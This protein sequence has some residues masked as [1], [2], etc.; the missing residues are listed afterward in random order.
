ML[1]HKREGGNNMFFWN[2]RKEANRKAKEEAEYHDFLTAVNVG[3]SDFVKKFVDSG[4]VHSRRCH[5]CKKPIKIRLSIQCPDC[6]CYICP[7][8]GGCCCGRNHIRVK[9]FPNVNK[10]KLLDDATRLYLEYNRKHGIKLEPAWTKHEKE[11]E[12][13]GYRKSSEELQ[14]DEQRRKEWLEKEIS[15]PDTTSAKA[16]M[17]RERRERINELKKYSNKSPSN[18][19]KDYRSC[20]VGGYFRHERFGKLYVEKVEANVLYCREED[21]TRRVVTKR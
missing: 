8:C 13:Y 18:S 9:K 20:R 19:Q 4:T 5:N 2:K 10:K 1:L 16:I 21:G 12:L 15:N 14:R 11:W 3:D 6:N 7:W 17:E